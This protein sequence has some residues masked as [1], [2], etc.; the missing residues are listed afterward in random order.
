MTAM[1]LASLLV[2]WLLA[3]TVGIAA[4]LWPRIN[5]F[6]DA[7]FWTVKLERICNEAVLFGLALVGAAMLLGLA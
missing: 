5:S 1:T 6:E 2:A 7:T 3:V 4:F